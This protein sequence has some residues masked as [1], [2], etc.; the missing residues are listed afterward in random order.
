MSVSL[1]SLPVVIFQH[2]FE[3]TRRALDEFAACSVGLFNKSPED[4]VCEAWGCVDP[5]S[6]AMCRKIPAGP[7]PADPRTGKPSSRHVRVKFFIRPIAS[8]I[9]AD[10]SN[11]IYSDI[12]LE[13]NGGLDLRYVREKWDLYN[14]EIIRRNKAGQ[15]EAYAPKNQD[16]LTASE[17]AFYTQHRVPRTLRIIERPS[18]L[19]KQFRRYRQ[20]LIFHRGRWEC[21]R[22]WTV[23]K[24]YLKEYAVWLSAPLLAK[25][26]M[27]SSR[28]PPE[29]IALL[30]LSHV[31]PIILGR[32]FARRLFVPCPWLSVD[33]WVDLYA[34]RV[35]MIRL[36]GSHLPKRQKLRSVRLIHQTNPETPIVHIPAS[37]IYPLGAGNSS[38]P[39]F[40]GVSWTIQPQD[41]WAVISA[42][43]SG[44]KTS[45]LQALT[46][47]LR[48]AP[49]PPPPNGL[50]PF[51]AGRDPFDYVSLVSFAHRPRA[52]GGAFYDYTARY[53]AVREEDKRTLRDTFFPESA[54]P[55]HDLAIPDFHA[56]PNENLAIKK[57]QAQE[58]ARRALFED[59]TDKL[60]LTQFLDLP[61]IALSN[62]QTRKARIVKALLEQP[63]LLIL[64]EPLTGLD[65][66]TRSLVLSLLRTLHSKNAP[67]V[68]LGMRAQDP[69]P[70]WT[71]HLALISKDGAVH[72]GTKEHILKGPSSASLHH[73]WR[74][75]DHTVSKKVDNTNEELIR[76]SGVNVSY[77]D[78][79]VDSKIAAFGRSSAFATTGPEGHSLDYTR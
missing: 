21:A 55:L 47:H 33:R 28:T 9:M 73:G 69:I 32:L 52:A 40:R 14:C 16:F 2:V 5:T 12:P 49:P 67:H 50:F 60:G 56:N 38:A 57:D 4:H 53:G 27:W 13:P 29:R 42:G 72:T 76:F 75:A 31:A 18:K 3:E 39:L 44:A 37:S 79:K 10:N 15:L 17:L 77:G 61:M 1:L 34:P 66:H 35:A 11:C 25:M 48:I 59:L 36:A 24:Q 41:A 62:G 63:E 30:T 65:V 19:L 8:R 43:S 6:R 70:E 64:D 58:R 54:R 51:L 68:I 20:N 45:L 7:F 46:G 71:T 23:R 74:P 22:D 78:R 26:K